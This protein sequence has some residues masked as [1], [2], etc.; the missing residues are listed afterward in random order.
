M[1]EQIYAYD[2][3]VKVFMETNLKKITYMQNLDIDIFHELVF[4]FR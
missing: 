3:D 4:N 1:K 2:D